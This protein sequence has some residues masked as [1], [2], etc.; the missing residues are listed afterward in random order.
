[1]AGETQQAQLETAI[2]IAQID[3]LI[4]SR[5][6]IATVAGHAALATPKAVTHAVATVVTPVIAA[7]HAFSPASAQVAPDSNS[8]SSTGSAV[9]FLI[10]HR[11]LWLK[12]WMGFQGFHSG[13]FK[14]F[15]HRKESSK[16]A[17]LHANLVAK[18]AIFRRMVTAYTSET[19]SRSST[20]RKEDQVYVY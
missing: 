4:G 19:G 11:L 8:G 16:S 20:Q 14:V 15:D 6:P 10:T 2:E 7:M 17:C 13:H 3:P 1:M 5:R 12:G 9:A 18:I